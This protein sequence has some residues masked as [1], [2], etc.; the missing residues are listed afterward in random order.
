[1]RW[2]PVLLVV[3]IP[4]A[5]AVGRET[6]PTNAR[7]VRP[8]RH[9]VRTSRHVYSLRQGD[10]VRVPAAATRCD[11]SAEAG[12]SNLTCRRAPVGR[13]QFVFYRDSVVVWGPA[14]PDK[15]VAR[16]HWER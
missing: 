8:S 4:V 5:F 7:P 10:V 9:V 1:M 6:A 15:E 16:Y 14:G 11:A 3:L 12:F 2:L 13:Y